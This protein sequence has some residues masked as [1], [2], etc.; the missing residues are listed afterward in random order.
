MPPPPAFFSH[1]YICGFYFVLFFLKQADISN[2]LSIK[3]DKTSHRFSVRRTLYIDHIVDVEW[4]IVLFFITT[5]IFNVIKIPGINNWG[6]KDLYW[7]LVSERFQS[8][9][10]R[11]P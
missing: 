6:N 10:A 7:L 8:I 1:L 9:I 11:K 3:W 5:I 4:V 2:C